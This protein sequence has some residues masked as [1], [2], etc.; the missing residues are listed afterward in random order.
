LQIE[1]VGGQVGEFA[2]AIGVERERANSAA[3][4]KNSVF[5]TLKLLVEMEV[6]A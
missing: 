6:A 4:S 5:F 2:L 3:A 1:I